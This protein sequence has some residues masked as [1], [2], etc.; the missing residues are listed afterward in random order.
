MLEI[1]NLTKVYEGGVQDRVN[2][3]CCGAAPGSVHIGTFDL[4]GAYVGIQLIPTVISVFAA[5]SRLSS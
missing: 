2:T 4:L 3:A 5:P 1:K